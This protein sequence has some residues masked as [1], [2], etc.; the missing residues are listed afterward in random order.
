MNFDYIDL[1]LAF[2]C[3]AIIGSAVGFLHPWIGP[4]VGVLGFILAIVVFILEEQEKPYE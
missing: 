4:V 1:L 3:G 2:A